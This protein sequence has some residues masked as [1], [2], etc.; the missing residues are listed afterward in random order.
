VSQQFHE[1]AA[2]PPDH[3]AHIEHVRFFRGFKST[4]ALA[5]LVMSLI[6]AAEGVVG[7]FGGPIVFKGIYVVGQDA[8]RASVG[9][10]VVSVLAA[11]IAV[12]V[13]IKPSKQ[14]DSRR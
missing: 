1:R 8:H 9:C 7:W 10:G 3:G 11:M 14:G 6:F 2:K 12:V 13:A 5:F 4:F